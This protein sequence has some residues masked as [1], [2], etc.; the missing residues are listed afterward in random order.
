MTESTTSAKELVQG[1]V[2]SFT[3]L[4]DE[5]EKRRKTA[6]EKCEYYKTE[7]ADGEKHAYLDASKKLNALLGKL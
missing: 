2:D 3:E 4:A 7:Y 6:S 1:L 5:A